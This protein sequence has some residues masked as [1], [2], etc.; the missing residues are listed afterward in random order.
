MTTETKTQVIPRTQNYVE[1]SKQRYS[2][3]IVKVAERN[4]RAVSSKMPEIPEE[5]R[6]NFRGFMPKAN[7]VGFRFF[8]RTEAET[9]NETL[10]GQPNN[11]SGWYYNVGGLGRE[12][13]LDEL[14]SLPAK[15]G[16]DGERTETL[17][18]MEAQ[19]VN[20][21]FVFKDGGYLLLQPEDVILEAPLPIE[22]VA[23]R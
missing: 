15:E 11:Y 8:D 21:V 22:E 23:R 2:N 12:V 20:R 6:M 9:G 16:W 18:Q 10:V 17:K 14:K 7:Y 5:K 1:Y 13:T 19:K 4:Y 3:L